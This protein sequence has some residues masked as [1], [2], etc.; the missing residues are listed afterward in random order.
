MLLLLCSRA[1]VGHGESAPHPA[2]CRHAASHH[3]HRH[4]IPVF[5]PQPVS[6]FFVRSAIHRKEK[7]DICVTWNDT[8][9]LLNT[10][11]RTAC[12]KLCLT[13]KP[14]GPLQNKIKPTQLKVDLGLC[15]T[16]A[17]P[18]A[19]KSNSQGRQGKSFVC[20]SSIPVPLLREPIP[21]DFTGFPR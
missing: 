20:S 4:E 6:L 7:T 5:I 10:F 19:F 21:S 2:D 11:E 9:E 18:S 1:G 17:V 14:L 13:S 12:F 3:H 16:R 8:E 15:V